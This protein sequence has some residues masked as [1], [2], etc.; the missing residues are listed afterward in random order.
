MSESVRRRAVNKR[1]RVPVGGRR[2]NLQLSKEDEDGFKERGRVTRWFNDQN[3]RVQAAEK[4]G[5]VFVTDDEARSIGS[6]G[7]HAENTDLN[8]KVSKVV[9][10]SGA[11]IRAYLMSIDKEWFDEDQETKEDRNRLIDQALNPTDQGG[12]SFDGAYTPR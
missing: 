7:L 12:Q 10:R 8:S 9:S 11:E 5:W 1:D 3:G 4:G 2:T 6:H